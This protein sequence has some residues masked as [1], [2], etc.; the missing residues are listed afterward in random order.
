MVDRLPEEMRYRSG[1]EVR[2]RLTLPAEGFANMETNGRSSLRE[3]L[4]N[5]MVRSGLLLRDHLSILVLT[6]LRVPSDQPVAKMHKA[7]GAMFRCHINGLV[8]AIGLCLNGDDDMPG[9]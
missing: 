8:H 1:V 3:Q 9:F 7:T 2:A 6:S 5:W 4:V